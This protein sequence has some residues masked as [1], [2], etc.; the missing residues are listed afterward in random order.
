MLCSDVFNLTF[1]HFRREQM[2]EYEIY[3]FDMKLL[4]LIT[5]LNAN[6]RTKVRDDYHGLTYLVETL[7]LIMKSNDTKELF[8]S[9][10]LFRV[11]FLIL[12]QSFSDVP[13]S[14]L[15]TQQIN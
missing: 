9:F 12:E 2:T 5:A 3:Y 8:V 6:V 11:R 15:S 7:D 1:F 14:V 10:K 13:E 4:F